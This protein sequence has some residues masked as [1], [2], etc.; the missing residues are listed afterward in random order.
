MHNEKLIKAYMTV[1]NMMRVVLV[2]RNIDNKGY[3]TSLI[4]SF[5]MLRR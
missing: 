5:E 3:A 4:K 1:R 2:C